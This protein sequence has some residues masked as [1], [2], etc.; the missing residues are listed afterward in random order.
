MLYL[1]FWQNGDVFFQSKEIT[2]YEYLINNYSLFDFESNAF[3]LDNIFFII[4]CPIILTCLILWV[5]PWVT[6][7]ALKKHLKTSSN[8]KMD[9]LI[10]ETE[11]KIKHEELEISLKDKTLQNID[12]DKEIVSK[13]KKEYSEEYK[14]FKSSMSNKEAFDIFSDIILRIDNYW[15]DLGIINIDNY[16]YSPAIPLKTISTLISLN[17]IEKDWY[18]FKFTTKWDLFRSLFVKEWLLKD[19]EIKTDV[20]F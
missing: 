11:Q 13:S 16:D 14:Q 19:M 12:K 5:F 10:N 8:E 20:P 18:N 4:V 3:L 7:K 17:L 9:I 15:W 2:K 1:A 6:S